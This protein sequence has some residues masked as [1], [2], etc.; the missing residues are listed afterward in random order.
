MTWIEAEEAALRVTGNH[1]F[2]VRFGYPS[3]ATEGNG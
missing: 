1:P 2:F 3:L